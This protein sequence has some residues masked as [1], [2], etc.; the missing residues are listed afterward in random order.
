MV[1]ETLT[2]TS[3]LLSLA[4]LGLILIS[5]ISAQGEYYYNDNSDSGNDWGNIND[6]Q[7]ESHEDILYQFVAPFLFVFVLLQFSLKK[8]LAFTFANDD[9]V[10][11]PLVPNNRGPNV[12]KEATIMALAISLMLV[13]S[14]YW[15]LIQTLAAGIGLLTVGG[16][17]LALLFIIYLFVS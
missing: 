5:S 2:S 11:H 10:E 15:S 14:P 17:I 6:T 1:E 13:A 12:S 4:F 8:T 16:L 9:E 3:K 7:F